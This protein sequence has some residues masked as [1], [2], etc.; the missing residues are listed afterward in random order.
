LGA[1]E[2]DTHLDAEIGCAGE[3]LH[4][5]PVGQGDFMFSAIDQRHV[6]VFE[7]FG[8]RVVNAGAAWRSR[9]GHCTGA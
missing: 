1:I 3:C 5:R 7:V 2:I 6:D 9:S 4:G 8:R